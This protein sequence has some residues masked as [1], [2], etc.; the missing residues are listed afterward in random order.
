MVGMIEMLVVVSFF[1]EYDIMFG[2]LGL[3]FFGYRVKFIDVDGYEIKEYNKLG[4]FFVQFF[5]VVLGYF[6]NEKVM[7]EMFVYDDDG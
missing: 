3:L 5:L 1:S 7:I 2:V 4:E 6:N